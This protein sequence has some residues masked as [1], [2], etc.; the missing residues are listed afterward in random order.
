MGRS[1]ESAALNMIALR[2]K[3]VDV[4][5]PLLNNWKAAVIQARSETIA[6]QPT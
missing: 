6:P 3:D 4:Q 1:L 2:S 5:F